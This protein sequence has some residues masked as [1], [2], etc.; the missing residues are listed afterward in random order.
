MLKLSGSIGHITSAATVAASSFDL[1]ITSPNEYL[2]RV[3]SQRLRQLLAKP[4]AIGEKAGPA[5]EY[6]EPAESQQEQAAE[7]SATPSNGNTKALPRLVRRAH[8]SAMR[9]THSLARDLRVAFGRVLPRAETDDSTSNNG[10]VVY[11]K[12]GN[13]GVLDGPKTGGGEGSGSGIGSGGNST[14]TAGP[15]GT[16]SS[17]GS[18][19]RT[20]TSTSAQPTATAVDSPWRLTNSYVSCLLSLLH[21]NFD[22]LTCYCSKE[23]PSFKDG[24]SSQAQIRR[25]VCASHVHRNPNDD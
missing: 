13:Q 9:R 15:Q 12:P 4:T 7:I 14:S 3:D 21:L 10:R 22:P 1:K 2:K 24:I 6:V 23:I 19:T 18:S 25:M 16:S 17:R 11:C 8:E 20:R 5:I